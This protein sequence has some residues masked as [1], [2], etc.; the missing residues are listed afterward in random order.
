MAKDPPRTPDAPTSSGRSSRPPSVTSGARGKLHV[1]LGVFR[2][3]DVRALKAIPGRRWNP[4]A[5]VWELPDTRDTRETL[6]Q[7][8]PQVQLP[9]EALPAPWT[10]ALEAMSRNMVLRGLSPR[11]RKVYRGQIRRFGRSVGKAPQ[12]VSADDIAEY[13]RVLSEVRKVSRS[14]HSQALSAIRYLFVHVLDRPV[15]LDRIPRPKRSRRLPFVLSRKEVARLLNVCR[16]PQEK[17]L[18]MMLYST[19]MRVGELVRM[20]RGDVDRDRRMVRVRQGKGAK[21]RYTLLSDRAV[22]ALD[23][24]LEYRR[25][26]GDDWLFPGGRPGRPLTARSVQKTV[27]RIG[28]RAGVQKK[29]T[30]HVLRHSF[31]THLLETGTDIRYIQ[32]L[33]GHA[34]TRTTEIYTHVSGRDLARIRNPLDSLGGDVEGGDGP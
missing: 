28:E 22:D 19:G 4:Q 18:I 5:S 1:R 29:V 21:D 27:A 3:S 30:P 12:Q 34:S 32:E 25:G 10:S 7:I 9:R 2:W 17:A 13:L 16:S 23:R 8:F 24:H 31:A 15:L 6:R 20:R 33:L 14:Y 26:T 11:T